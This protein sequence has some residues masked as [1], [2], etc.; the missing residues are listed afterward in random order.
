VTG[1]PTDFELLEEKPTG[2]T[3]RA[4]EVGGC[5]PQAGA[6]PTHDNERKRTMQMRRTTLWMVLVIAMLPLA[7]M[8]Q[9]D[10]A[11]QQD[12]AMAPADQAM[13]QAE[14]DSSQMD[15]CKAMMA[16]HEQ[17]REQMK[18]QMAANDAE[19][20]RLVAEMDSATGEAQVAATAAVVKELV[21]QHEARQGMMMERHPMMMGHGM[22]HEGM[23]HGMMHEGMGH[24]MA[25][26]PM[27]QD[28]QGEDE[29][30]PADDTQQDP[31]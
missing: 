28:M 13:M 30:A 22:K 24:G 6:H 7:A 18:Q 12:G 26:C 31:E 1:S 10:S 8:A 19:L 14:G 27:M 21:K 3:N 23:G 20:D 15:S 9:D 16:R 29:P 25:D 11:A 2:S 17:M 5:S 4:P